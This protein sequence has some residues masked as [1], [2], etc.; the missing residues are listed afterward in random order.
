VADSRKTVKHN[1]SNV[2]WF[3]LECIDYP[4]HDSMQSNK[5][6]KVPCTLQ[7]KDWTKNWVNI[8]MVGYDEI[9]MC[10]W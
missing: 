10:Y 2:V 5:S 3:V 6:G 8:V 1:S 7:D 4:K 9:D